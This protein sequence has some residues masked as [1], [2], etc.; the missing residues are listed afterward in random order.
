MF[1]FIK[2]YTETLGGADLYGNVALVIF[3]MVFIG[4]LWVALKADKGYIHAK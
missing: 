3:V 2:K 4:M 1:S